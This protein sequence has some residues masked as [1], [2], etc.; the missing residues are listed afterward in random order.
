MPAE[1]IRIEGLNE[2][3][4]NLKTLDGDLP[5]AVRLAFNKAADLVVSDAAPKVP[6]KSGRA[7]RS[8]KSKSSQRFARVVG[9]NA[10]TPY[11][12]WLDFGGRVGRNN[13]IR[14]PYFKDGR[15]IYQAFFGLPS[16]RIEE[17]MT[18]ALLDVV[19]QAGIEVE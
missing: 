5:K 1:P 19:R 4:R 12:P 18:D 17:V 13:S 14:R 6:S 8:V 16:G 3:V 11:Y 9:G 15:Y 7:R 2:F 10:R